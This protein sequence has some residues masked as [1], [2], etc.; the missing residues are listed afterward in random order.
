[1][2]NVSKKTVQNYF[3]QNCEISTNCKHFWHKDGKE[4]KLMSD[5]LICHL[6]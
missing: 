6:T 4:D 2:Y 5:E 3:C 1:M